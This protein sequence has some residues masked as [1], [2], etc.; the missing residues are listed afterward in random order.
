MDHDKNQLQ[1]MEACRIETLGTSVFLTSHKGWFSLMWRDQ[2]KR[3]QIHLLWKEVHFHTMCHKIVELTGRITKVRP[4][5]IA[6]WISTALVPLHF[7]LSASP[8][9]FCLSVSMMPFLM[10]LF[11]FVG[12]KCKTKHPLSGLLLFFK[13]QKLSKNI[14]RSGSIVVFQWEKLKLSGVNEAILI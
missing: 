3:E 7:F 2:K 4:V 10:H 14:H 9:K 11:Q 6:V 5:L 8:I 1:N 12:T 13:L